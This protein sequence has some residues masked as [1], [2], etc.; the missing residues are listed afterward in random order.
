MNGAD[1][2]ALAL[3][4]GAV[5]LAG[6]TTVYEPPPGQPV[7]RLRLVS[8]PVPQYRAGGR[9]THLHVADLSTCP[10]SPEGVMRFGIPGPSEA[11]HLGMPLPLDAGDRF[12]SE[13]VLPAGRPLAF[14]LNTG[15]G[16][17][18]CR[19]AFRFTLEPGRDYEIESL[20]ST[21]LKKCAVSVRELKKAGSGTQRVRLTSARKLD[22]RNLCG[23]PASEMD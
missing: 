15:A 1:L 7:A 8:A 12:S 6:C 2:R 23:A 9:G 5:V 19:V 13:F 3:A 17:L 18:F 14:T 16:R 22:E 20:W 11:T 21:A 4:V 10:A